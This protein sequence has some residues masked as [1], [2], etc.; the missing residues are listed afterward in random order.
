MSADERR[1]ANGPAATTMRRAQLLS[2]RPFCRSCKIIRRLQKK[3]AC[4]AAV[5]SFIERDC[6]LWK[7]SDVA[8]HYIFQSLAGIAENFRRFGHGTARRSRTLFSNGQIRKQWIFH[9]HHSSSSKGRLGWSCPCRNERP[10][11]NIP[12]PNSHPELEK[13]KLVVEF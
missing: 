1:P 9:G 10:C 5:D 13:K 6:Y 7:N 2:S 8:V 11:A 4:S 12:K 3:P